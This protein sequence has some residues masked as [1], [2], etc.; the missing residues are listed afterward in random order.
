MMRIV[1]NLKKV[2][3][4]ARSE[5]KLLTRVIRNILGN[6]RGIEF[7]AEALGEYRRVAAHVVQ[8]T[9]TVLH[10]RL[11]CRVLA[12]W[13]HKQGRATVHRGRVIGLQCGHTRCS[14]EVSIVVYESIL[15]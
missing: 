3:E 1:G 14:V 7:E 15:L 8:A 2:T 4:L 13:Q 6:S 11:E 12:R 10:G 5:S 9:T